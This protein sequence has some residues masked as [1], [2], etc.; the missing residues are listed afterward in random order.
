MASAPQDFTSGQ[1]LTASE[2]DQLPQGIISKATSTSNSSSTSGNTTLDIITATAVTPITADRRWRVTFRW[3]GFTGTASGDAFSFRVQEGSTVLHENSQI[4]NAASV[5]IGGGECT[6]IIDG[7]TVAPHT[8]KGTITRTLGS[9]ATATVNGA[10]TYPIT[11]T[12][13]DV[14]QI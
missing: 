3:R 7:P 12:V 4:V 2:M 14:G 5:G 8:Y 11:I 10:S 13:E 9:T 1:V 6:A